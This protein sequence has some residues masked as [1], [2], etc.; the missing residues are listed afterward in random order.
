MTPKS[1]IA[2]ANK[3]SAVAARM[4]RSSFMTSFLLGLRHRESDVSRTGHLRWRVVLAFVVL[5]APA[6]RNFPHAVRGLGVG[7][8]GGHAAAYLK[9]DL[10]VLRR[11]MEEDRAAGTATASRATG[12]PD[13]RRVLGCTRRHVSGE[14]LGAGV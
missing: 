6:A 10:R 4:E 7:K 12:R 1:A 2:A 13:G 5:D 3:A 9:P 11:A 8:L 14:C